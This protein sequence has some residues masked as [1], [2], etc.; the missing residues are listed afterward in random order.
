DDM[1]A[2]IVTF[3]IPLEMDR[4]A[5]WIESNEL[6]SAYQ[7]RV[8]A[9]P[10]K[11]LDHRRAR[12]RKLSQPP[13]VRGRK[14]GR[15]TQAKATQEHLMEW[16]GAVVGMGPGPVENPVRNVLQPSCEGGQESPR[17]RGLGRRLEI[18]REV[19]QP[20]EVGR[21]GVQV[22]PL[23]GRKDYARAV[24]GQGQTPLLD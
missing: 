23:S 4:T 2:H 15:D 16:L 20:A 10:G 19:D 21:G 1:H 5:R 7:P 3:H 18:G 13:A 6:S 12:R 22:N 9:Y 24:V 8:C 14:G 11:R 17:P